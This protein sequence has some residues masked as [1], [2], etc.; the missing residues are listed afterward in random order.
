MLKEHIGYVKSIFELRDG[1]LCSASDDKA[2]K[3]WGE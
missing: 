3:I 1:R 2:L